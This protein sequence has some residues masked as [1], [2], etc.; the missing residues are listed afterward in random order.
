M[1]QLRNGFTEIVTFALLLQQVK[2]VSYVLCNGL[3][4]FGHVF[5]HVKETQSGA[6]QVAN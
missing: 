6:F 4:G 2:D 5:F 3:W 1:L